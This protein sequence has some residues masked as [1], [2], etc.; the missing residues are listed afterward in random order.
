MPL[1]AFVVNAFSERAFSGNPAAVVFL[2]SPRDD[3]WRLAAAI[4]FGHSETAFVEESRG[5]Y[6]LRWFTPK[7]EVPLCGH[8]TLAAAHAK[9]L[10]PAI[11]NGELPEQFAA[12]SSRRFD[13]RA[14]S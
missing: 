6:A 12:F 10:A 9:L 7:L 14:H 2:D 8:A 13:V 4:K 1:Q 5:A 3:A 11:L